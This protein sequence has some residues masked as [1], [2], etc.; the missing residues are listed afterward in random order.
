[1]GI[2][3]FV[4]DSPLGNCSNNGMSARHKE[5]CITNVEG[6]FVPTPDMP[7][8]KLVVRS[9]GNLICVPDDI[10]AGKWKMFGGAFVFTSDSR[11]SEK[12]REL[13]GYAY[14]FPVAIHDRVE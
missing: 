5:V 7:A 12:V 9:T 1:M 14:G 11:F 3:A 13:T 10:P 4:Y 2:M 6:P 8:C